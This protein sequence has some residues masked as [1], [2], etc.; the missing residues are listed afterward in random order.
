MTYACVVAR[1]GVIYT[2]PHYF[3]KFI[4]RQPY[5]LPRDDCRSEFI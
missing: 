1:H 5:N 2:A 3:A 4:S